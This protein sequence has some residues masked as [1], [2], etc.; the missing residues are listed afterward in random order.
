MIMILFLVVSC[1]VAHGSASCADSPGAEK[2][3]NVN[4]KTGFLKLSVSPHSA[5]MQFIIVFYP[6]NG[7]AFDINEGLIN[8]ALPRI[9]G[10]CNNGVDGYN[11]QLHRVC[12]DNGGRI[13]CKI[14]QVFDDNGHNP[15]KVN[16]TCLPAGTKLNVEFEITTKQ[17]QWSNGKYN[18]D[19]ICRKGHVTVGQKGI[20]SVTTGSD[21]GNSSKHYNTTT[22]F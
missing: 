13:S 7:A 19:W 11:Y 17:K 1:L 2:L 5:S 4:W 20:V 10:S 18:S 8:I 6:S 14:D 9:M 22:L 3:F 16:S 12:E 15:G 21:T